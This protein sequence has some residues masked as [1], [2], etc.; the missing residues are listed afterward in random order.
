[1]K[2]ILPLSLLFFGLIG[3][4]RAQTCSTTISTFP[5]FENFDG[6]G[7]TGWVS[8][9][10]NP[11]WA[12]GTPAKAIINSAASGTKSWITGLTGT[13]NLSEQS[14][15]E[16]PC[17]NMSTLALPVVELK[18]WW[19]CENSYDGAV[20]QS[21]IDNGVTWQK[22]GS[23][24]DPINWYNDNTI[25]SGPGGQTP[26]TAEGWTG[27]NLSANG[28]GGWLSA[29]HVLTGLGGQANV[30]LRIAFGS[31]NVVVDE[32][33]AFDNFAVYDTPANDAGLVSIT[34]PVSPVT[35]G[36]PTPVMVTVK[37]YGTAP[38]TT[39]TFGYSVNG[40]VQPT[41]AWSGNVAT[42]ATSAPV[43]IGTSTFPAGVHT[44]KSWSKL[45][46]GFADGNPGNDSTSISFHSCDPLTG[47]YTINKNLPASAT[48]FPSLSA[49]A[50]VLGNCGISGPVAFSVAAGTGPYYEQ[51]VLPVIPG[52]T[53]TNTVTFEGNGNTVMAG[54]GPSD[55]GVI[56]LKGADF[57]TINNF[58]ITVD[59][60]AAT[61]WGVQLYNA[62]DNNTFTNNVVTLPVSSAG[63]TYNGIVTGISNIFTGGNFANNLLIQNNTI[64]GGYHNI[65][66]NGITT[67]TPTF[68]NRV[69]NNNLLDAANI[70]IYLNAAGNGA[71]IENNDISR[72]TRV[73]GAGFNGIYVTGPNTNTFI[74]KN[75]IHNTHD[76]MANTNNSVYGIYMGAVTTLGNENMVQNNLIYNINNSNGTIY[77][78]YVSSVGHTH[79]YHNTIS[80]DNPAVSLSSVRGV[81]LTGALAN[82][83]VINNNVSITSP[84]TTKH[85][86]YL[87]TVVNSLVS[88]NNNFFVGTTGNIGFLTTDKPTL[89]DWK[90]VNSNA[91]D[92]NSVSADPIFVANS[93]LQPLASAL[94]NS[95]QAAPAVTVDIN[96]NPRSA[97]APDMGAFEFTPAVNDAGITAIS[98]P[99]SPVTPGSQPVQVSLRNFGTAALTSATIGWKV[100][101]IAQPDYT[102]SGNVASLQTT[103]TPVQIG[104]YNFVA[105]NYT[106]KVWSKI[107]NGQPDA[108]AVNDTTIML[109]NSCTPLAGAYTINKNSATAG[110]NFQTFAEVTERLN[111]C[112]VSA[113]VTF[114]VVSGTGPYTEQIEITTIPFTSAANTVTFEGNGNTV[115]ANPGVKPGVV[116]LNGA[117]YVKVNNFVLTLEPMAVTSGNGWG[118]QLMNAADHNTIS[119]NTINLPITGVPANIYGISSGSTSSSGGNHTNFTKIQNNVINGGYNGI[120]LY[121]T[122]GTLLLENNEVTGNTVKDFYLTGI[123][124]QNVKGTL[125]ESNDI[126][127]P[128]RTNGSSFYGI[129]MTSAGNTNIISKNRIHNTHDLATIKTGSAY[130]LYISTPATVGNENIIKNNVI[131]GFNNTG[132]LFYGIMN[133]GADG[134]HFFNNTISSD[135]SYSY[136][137]QRGIHFTTAVNNVKFINNN[138][139]LRG[140]ANNAYGIF[141]GSSALPALISNNNNLHISLTSGGAVGYYQSDKVTLAD[142]QAVNINPYDQNSVSTDPI[143]V[144][145]ASGNL[146]PTSAALNNK[147]QVVPGVTE[148]ILGA[149]RNATT[150]DIGAYEFGVTTNDVG[151]TAISVPNTTG[152]SL[153]ATETVTVTIMNY[154]ANTQTSVPVS[155]TVNGTNL[156]SETYTGSLAPNTTATY[157]FTA[158]ANLATAGTHRIIANTNL[159]GDITTVNDA[160]TLDVVNAMLAGIPGPFNFETLATGISG[161]NTVTRPKSAISEGTAASLPFNGQPASSTKGMIME[162]IVNPAWVMPAGTVDPWTNNPD[163]FSAATFCFSPAGGTPTDPLFLSFDLKQLYKTANANTNFRVTVNGTQVGPTY[164]PP[165]SGTPIN[166]QKVYVDLTPFKNL[167]IIKLGLESSVAEPFANGAGTANL[168]DNIRIQR[169]NPTGV[170]ETAL[171]SQLHVFPN[172]STGIF[173]VD[174]PQ[175]KAFAMEVTD[176]TG[177]VVMKESAAAKNAQVDLSKAAKGI[178]LLKVTSEG[179][180]VV[181]KLI[182]E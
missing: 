98:S 103:T 72:P 7:P 86:I 51:L 59:P 131:Y 162:G 179:S 33:F 92:Q 143:F 42:N 178:Y 66:L 181:R 87:N 121:G 111:T 64:I 25:N 23:K 160:D 4:A 18:V 97:T 39:A 139:S 163:N 138:I 24:G 127:R 123:F 175:G 104:T 2:K 150:P 147:G 135:H 65:F 37:N 63:S 161:L 5:Y 136:S 134:A 165:F 118:V 180:S 114:S 88:N 12:L 94:D 110:T 9:G 168:V 106:V 58:K 152:C 77:G 95:G 29:K 85:A 116:V 74:S 108:L 43:Q 44:I 83:K 46:N 171:A 82:V 91:Y 13:Y 40:V 19:N 182:V 107:P 145:Y 69:L 21:S 166:W 119:N 146:K 115:S 32:G 167:A 54:S 124:L 173:N 61:G 156:V 140:T 31:D 78:I 137:T 84:A 79:L 56:T 101:G 62:S 6:A 109:I 20:L 89:N 14:F 132:G 36:A 177:R 141:W 81:Y 49:V 105:G 93:Y 45:P 148:D 172:P 113:P 34:S 120:Q 48:N 176:L 30:K 17:F 102:W 112:G 10:T 41:F 164:R 76:L 157:N 68:G 50:T 35:P 70:G 128:T 122:G 155:Y 170:K 1:M 55:M 126:S 38:L 57:V 22:V 80:L 149:V 144:N 100:N 11:S 26:A 142:W 28:S 153:T 52:T 125:V 47:N 133:A 15:V 96:G 75:R 60:V 154:G 99:T 73:I 3:G 130:A 158:K 117:D 90:A 159:S 27:R 169:L 8:G 71:R 151:I 53:A 174:L 129:Q 16:S 67:G